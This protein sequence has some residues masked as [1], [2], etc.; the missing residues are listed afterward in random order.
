MDF[1]NSSK[2]IHFNT[3]FLLSGCMWKY[4]LRSTSWKED[5]AAMVTRKFEICSKLLFW[6]AWGVG[7]PLRYSMNETKFLSA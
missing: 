1:N 4:D 7:A 6:Q 2:M 3:I 5:P